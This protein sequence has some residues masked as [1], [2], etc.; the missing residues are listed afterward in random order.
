MHIEEWP[1]LDAVE[2]VILGSGRL[3]LPQITTTV[4]LDYKLLVWV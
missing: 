4:R 2:I 3:G 1:L